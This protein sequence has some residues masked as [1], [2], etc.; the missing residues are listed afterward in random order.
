MRTKKSLSIVVLFILSGLMLSC[1]CVTEALCVDWAL[2]S[3]FKNGDLLYYDR[4]SIDN[5]STNGV[6]V[7]T[8]LE[9]SNRGLEEH[10][11]SIIEE[12][13]SKG[14]IIKRGYDRLHYTI[15][16]WKMRCNVDKSCLLGFTDYDK[17]EKIVMSHNT[18]IESCDSIT[19]R[20]PEI[21][22]IFEMLCNKQ[23]AVK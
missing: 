2:F 16:V 15:I 19:P 6:K 10:I 13:S 23:T 9:Y 11:K 12:G 3:T 21:H 14:E 4:D 8:K 22:L 7:W 17:D 5:N 18:A 20:A 1:L